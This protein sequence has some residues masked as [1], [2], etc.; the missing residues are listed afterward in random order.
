MK[1]TRPRDLLL[2][3][4]FDFSHFFIIPKNSIILKTFYSNCCLTLVSSRPILSE[5]VNNWICCIGWNITQLVGSMES[6]A[7]N[8]DSW[9]ISP[10]LL[11]NPEGAPTDE[12]YT[13]P[14]N[15]TNIL[16]S[17]YIAHFSERQPDYCN[18]HFS[19][20]G[21]GTDT[22]NRNTKRSLPRLRL[23]PAVLGFEVRRLIHS[24]T[25]TCLG[26]LL[27]FGFVFVMFQLCNKALYPT[28]W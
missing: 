15:Y 13:M 17:T 21:L 26:K 28:V 18:C 2:H 1:H 19:W 16:Y 5:L 25:V 8:L 14:I 10:P 24:A 23:E 11:S 7:A 27:K 22:S 12:K 20:G 6:I 9:Y 3:T 4:V